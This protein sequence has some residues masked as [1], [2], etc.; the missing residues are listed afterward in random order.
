MS[1]NLCAAGRVARRLFLTC[2]DKAM[3]EATFQQLID[4]CEQVGPE[5]GIEGLEAIVRANEN[6]QAHL[7]GSGSHAQIKQAQKLSKT[8]AAQ[9]LTIARLKKHF[10][11]K[12]K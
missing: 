7:F 2:K 8:I 4:M 3:Q 5:K 9:N 11:D 1:Y 6:A 10:P 12:K